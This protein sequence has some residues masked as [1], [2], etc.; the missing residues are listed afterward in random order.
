MGKQL[1]AHSPGLR[2]RDWKRVVDLLMRG[3]AVSVTTCYKFQSV[4]MM[5]STLLLPHP[6]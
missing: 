2:H 6:A 1:Y 5:L 4:R 3:K